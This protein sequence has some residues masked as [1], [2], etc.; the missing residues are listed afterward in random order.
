MPSQFVPWSVETKKANKPEPIVGEAAG[1]TRLAR[2]GASLARPNNVFD[3]IGQRTFVTAETR[4]HRLQNAF[5]H[6]DIHVEWVPGVICEDGKQRKLHATITLAERVNG[7]YLGKDVRHTPC[8]IFRS[9]ILKALLRMQEGEDLLHLSIDIFRVAEPVST[10]AYADG[11][12]LTGP[13]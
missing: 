10:L 1:F 8:E 11:S 9:G 4:N 5:A 6:N 3:E 7:I 2:A 13:L 12:G